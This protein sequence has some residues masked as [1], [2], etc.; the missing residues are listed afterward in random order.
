MKFIQTIYKDPLGTQIRIAET[1]HCRAE[2]A[3]NNKQKWATIYVIETEP[4]FH[5]QGFASAFLEEFKKEFQGFRIGCTVALND[6]MRHLLE[7]HQIH[8][9]RDP[10]FEEFIQ[11]LSHL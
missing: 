7:K 11:E 9:Y 8:E 1:P 10:D 6:K 2:I 4:K 3:S 5:N